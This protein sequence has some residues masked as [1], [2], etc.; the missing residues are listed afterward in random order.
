MQ[1]PKHVLFDRIGEEAV[2]IDL[3]TGAYYVINE[4][5][6]EIFDSLKGGLVP[7][8]SPSLKLL[9]LEGLI[10]GVA[11]ERLEFKDDEVPPFEK[12]TDLESLL[13]ADPVHD[14]D[15]YGW[16]KLS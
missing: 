5:G 1:I 2:A 15:E 7:N 9:V 12:F 3:K 4:V 8:F 6:A 13:A 11:I 16:P 10:D 14:V